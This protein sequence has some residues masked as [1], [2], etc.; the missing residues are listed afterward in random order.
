MSTATPALDLPGGLP[1]HSAPPPGSAPPESP[2]APGEPQPRTVIRPTRGW[3]GLKLGEVWAFR[4]LLYTLGARNVK[5]VYKQTLLGVAWVLLQPLIGAGLF[6]FV[7]GVLA[8]MPSGELP[9]F[10][11]SFAGMLGWTLFSAT[12][13]AS[14][15]VMVSN[16]HLVSK[17]YFPRLILPLSAASQPL[18]NFLVSLILMAALAVMYSIVPSWRLLLL[19]VW[20]ALL[21]MLAVGIGFWLSSIMVTYRDLRY[22]VPVGVQF[23]LYAS[24]VGYSVAAVSE[25][26]PASVERFYM[27]N[28]LAGLLEGFRWSLLNEGTLTP[29]WTV[30]SVVVAPVVLVVGA[31]LFRRAEKRFADVI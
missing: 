7:F 30:Y 27:L 26:V 3:A 6:A 16:A 15:M 21:L 22:I 12:L 2:G 11:F 19:P 24:P 13:T 17:I 4:D 23:L 28:P 20:S 29:G 5:L 9:Y 1:D 18:V 8:E 14:S 10:V 31:C 25:K